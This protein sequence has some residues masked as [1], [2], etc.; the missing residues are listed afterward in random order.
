[1]VKGIARGKTVVLGLPR[2]FAAGGTDHDLARWQ[3]GRIDLVVIVLLEIPERILGL[4]F[5]VGQNQDRPGFAGVGARVRQHLVNI[6]E[7]DDAQAHLP[8]VARALHAPRRFAGLLDRGQEQRDKDTDDG[9]DDEQLD[10]RKRR[11]WTIAQNHESDSPE[12]ENDNFTMLATR[13]LKRQVNGAT[14]RE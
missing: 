14:R 11:A 7:V 9:D 1:M 8:E 4:L 2:W 3:A 6:F 13:R 12:R 5:D 10:E